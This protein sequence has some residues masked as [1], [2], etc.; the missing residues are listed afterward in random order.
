VPPSFAFFIP[1][2]E[3]RPLSPRFDRP[4]RRLIEIMGVQATGSMVQQVNELWNQL[5]I[6]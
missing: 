5:G 6:C 4:N 3:D 2:A 1:K